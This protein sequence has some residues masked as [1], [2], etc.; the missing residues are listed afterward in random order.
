MIKIMSL[1]K[2]VGALVTTV[3]IGSVT[4]LIATPKKGNS[5]KIRATRASKFTQ[6]RSEEKE[7]L[8]I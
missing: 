6:K 5:S 7:D 3:L 8:F 4:L 1:T 2:S